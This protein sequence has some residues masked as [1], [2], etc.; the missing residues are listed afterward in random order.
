MIY[1]LVVKKLELRY[2]LKRRFCILNNL[3]IITV[4]YFLCPAVLRQVTVYGP[5]WVY[6]ESREYSKHNCWMLDRIIKIQVTPHWICGNRD[7]GRCL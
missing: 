2:S 3:I 1:N 7:G 5:F 4:R 6:E